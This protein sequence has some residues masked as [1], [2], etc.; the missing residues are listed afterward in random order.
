MLQTKTLK[1]KILEP[2][3]AKLDLLTDEWN[4]YQQFIQLEEKGLDWIADTIQIYA[5]YKNSVRWYWKNTKHKKDFPI[6]LDNQTIKIKET[7]NKLS[8][9]WARI[10]VKGK[11]G[12]IWIAIKPHKVFPQEYKLGESKLIKKDNKFHLHIV[13]K[14][15]I[16]VRQ[17]FENIISIDLGE[18]VIATVLHDGKPIFM[19]R[20]VRGIR[21]H[22]AWLR[23]RLGNKKLP[24]VIKKV[25]HRE[26][27]KINQILHDIS[28]EIVELAIKTPNSAISLGDLKGISKSAKNKGKRF[29]RIVSSMPYYKLT[30]YITYKA[31]WEGIS[32][33][34]INERNTSKTCSKCG[35]SDKKNRQTQGCFKCKSC[36]YQVNADF[37]GVLNIHKRSLEQASKDRALLKPISIREVQV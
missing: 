26:Q 35:Y 13:V 12:G 5:K 21:R 30:Q 33:I 15:E 2:T 32:V 37:N 18:K 25:G 16:E 3:Q 6:S 8:K 29:N 17:Q 28:K 11:R 14:K 10:P 1:C 22:Y 27:N 34:K 19:G 20:E 7:N 4:K 36:G 31:N 9:Y 23:K 24:K